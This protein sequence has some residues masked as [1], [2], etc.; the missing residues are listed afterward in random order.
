M[1]RRDDLTRE[2]LNLLEV[3]QHGLT[4]Y[5]VSHEYIACIARKG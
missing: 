1:N 5:A 4:D 3:R 2:F